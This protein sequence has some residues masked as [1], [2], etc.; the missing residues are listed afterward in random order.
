[1][2]QNS[3]VGARGPLKPYE[4]NL[5]TF[6]SEPLVGFPFDSGQDAFVLQDAAGGLWL[7]GV[8]DNGFLVTTSV[9]VGT[10]ITV[11]LNDSQQTTSWRLFVT[12]TGWLMDSQVLF[13][14]TYPVF[15]WMGAPTK[16]WG[17][18]VLT[19]GFLITQ[20]SPTAIDE[21][22]FMG[23]VKVSSSA[24]AYQSGW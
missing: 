24:S 15:R 3:T 6:G 10:P 9:T 23:F 18:G 12:T 13:L 1:M 4:F 7:V 19:N 16:I 17:L 2:A 14:P 8:Q 20:P 5:Q 11:I 22:C 21:T